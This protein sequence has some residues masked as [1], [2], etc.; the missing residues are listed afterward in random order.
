MSGTG[1]D[2]PV[3]DQSLTTLIT[4]QLALIAAL[5]GQLTNL[6]GQA[7]ANLSYTVSGPT[8]SRTFDWNGYRRS[9]TDQLTAANAQL[10]EY[11]KLKQINKPYFRVAS[12]RG[13]CF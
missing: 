4:N 3:V 12:R 13:P 5:Q 2:I 11:F 6:A 9:L 10:E 1:D 8:G 7:G